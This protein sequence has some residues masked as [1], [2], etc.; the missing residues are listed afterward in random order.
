MWYLE[1]YTVFISHIGYRT[2]IEFETSDIERES[3]SIKYEA[4]S[5]GYDMIYR[6][7]IDFDTRIV[8]N[9]IS[10]IER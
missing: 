6:T 4:I 7:R 5:N 1:R 9:T 2:E 3:S 10:D 8:F